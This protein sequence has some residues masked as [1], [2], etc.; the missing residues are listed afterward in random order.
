MVGL[1]GRGQC[2]A[3]LSGLIIR[4][5]QIATEGQAGLAGRL[6]LL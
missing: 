5:L 6:A 4:P 3:R 2:A 1:G